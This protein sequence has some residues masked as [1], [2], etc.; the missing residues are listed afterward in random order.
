MMLII[1]G[2]EIIIITIATLFY[3]RARWARRN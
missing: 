2:L 3:L 1:A